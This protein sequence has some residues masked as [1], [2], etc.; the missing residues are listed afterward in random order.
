[1]RLRAASSIA[2]CALAWTG[3]ARAQSPPAAPDTVAVGDWQLAP[4][5][6]L[7]TRGEY[8][9]DP[10][11]MGGSDLAGTTSARVRNAYG[12]LERTRVGL[13]AERGALSAQV[14]IQDAR[15]WGVPSPSGVLGGQPSSLASLGAYE[16]WI[17]ARTSSARPAF[18]RIGR[19]PVTWGE[20]RLLS[21]AD[22][23]PAGRSLDAIRARTSLG[24]F[25]VEALAA[26]LDTPRPLGPAL[27][28]TS[29]PQSTGT[30]LY[31]ARVSAGL[32]PLLAFELALLA[33]VARSDVAASDGSR[34]GAAR[35]DGETYVG[36][37]RVSGDASGWRYAV[38]GAYELGRATALAD[39]G[40][41]AWAAAAWVERRVD[42]IVWTPSLRLEGD[43]ASGD[44]RG[45]TYRQFD[46]IL[47]DVHAWHGAMDA[48]AWSNAAQASA[49]VTL[50]PWT[51]ERVALEYRYARLADASGEWLDAYLGAVGRGNA[52]DAELGHEVDASATWRPWRELDLALGYSV[53]ALGDGARAILAAQDRGARQADGSIA[54]APIAHAAYAQAT[55]RV[56]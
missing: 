48:L 33:R 16:A 53:M 41:A 29:G 43:Y 1:V 3:A 19:Q 5:L 27:P 30:Q 22:W 52:S 25:D 24:L 11:D 20:G 32:D 55:L 31:G 17:E 45:G 49:R 47:P 51:E 46:P 56:P 34:F 10:V 37:L 6:E 54:T 18:V 8:R 9:R 2:A 44:D 7:R 36:D 14:T 39:A 42:A 21:S 50:S 12:V 15:A 26:I 4:T 23:S 38:E 40:V 13:G 28:D 35:A